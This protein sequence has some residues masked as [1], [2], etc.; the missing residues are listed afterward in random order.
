[1][2]L[3]IVIPALN[4]EPVIG[5]SIE[6]AT[7]MLPLHDVYVVSDGSTDAVSR[8]SSPNITAATACTLS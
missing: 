1:M 3:A 2:T 6:S 5:A 7:R 4:E 8:T